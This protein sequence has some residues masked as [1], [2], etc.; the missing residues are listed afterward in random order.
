MKTNQEH[1][2]ENTKR[3][4][5]AALGGGAQP[6]PKV[7][8]RSLALLTR[9]V[10]RKP[11]AFP[12]M[13]LAMLG[14]LALIMAGLCAARYASLD[15]IEAALTP[16]HLVTVVLAFNM[17]TIPFAGLVIIMRRRSDV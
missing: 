16:T 4:I 3:L 8:S 6:S 7:R 9:Q 13:A 5:R 10:L 2:E 17:V 15:S 14:G 1:L 12:D 11:S